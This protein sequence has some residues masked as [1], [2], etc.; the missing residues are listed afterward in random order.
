M[1]DWIVF[2]IGLALA[3]GMVVLGVVLML[4]GGLISFG[5]AL[6]F[7]IGAYAIGFMTRFGIHE[8]L[9]TLPAA[10]AVS[11]LV[12]AVL[13]LLMTRFRGIYFAML[14]LALSMVFYTVLIKFY[15][16]SGGSDGIG[17]HGFRLAG[18]APAKPGLV[19]YYLILACAAAALYLAHRFLASPLGYLMQAVR[20]NEI[21]I[22]YLGASAGQAIYASYVLAGAMGGLGGALVAYSVGH[23]SPE[24]SFW[25]TSGDFVF[26]AVLGGIGSAFA[27]FTGSIVFELVKNYALKYSPNTW[28]MTLGIFLLLVIFFQPRGLWHLVA[29]W[30]RKSPPNMS[31]QT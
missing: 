18:F 24:L 14:S 9:V 25:T 20:Y 28:Q 1:S 29:R 12:A 7:A 23:V 16:I 4:R 8:A 15:D 30:Q 11:T 13:G 21:R 10:I 26:V 5:Q 19:Q 31:R 2:L 3:K 17:V 27:P 22:E 6:Y